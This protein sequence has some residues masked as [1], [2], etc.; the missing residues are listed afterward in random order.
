MILSI[1]KGVMCVKEGIFRFLLQGAFL[2][3][4]SLSKI[5]R[6]Q[7]LRLSDYFRRLVLPFQ[8]M[9]VLFDDRDRQLFED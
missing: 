3:L 9:G 1:D 4:A 8:D 2:I 6:G 5:D 7:V